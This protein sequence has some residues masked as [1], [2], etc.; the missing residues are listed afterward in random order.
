MHAVAAP[1]TVGGDCQY[2]NVTG[3]GEANVNGLYTL[4]G[5][6]GASANGRSTWKGL[7]A[8][9]LMYEDLGDD[10]DMAYV[11][12]INEKNAYTARGKSL[13]SPPITGW[14]RTSRK[15]SELVPVSAHPTPRAGSCSGL[16]A[17]S[18]PYPLPLFAR[19]QTFA[20]VALPPACLRAR[21]TG[22]GFSFPSGSLLTRQPATPRSGTRTPDG[23]T[24]FYNYKIALDAHREASIEWSDAA[25]S[26][27][28]FGSSSAM[29]G[30][31]RA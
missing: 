18:A 7:H 9:W 14:V 5:K 21:I 25:S 8:S 29:W 24:R 26:G 30:S 3:S 2:V 17:L 15:I 22:S 11:L 12:K 28:M 20:C 19:S 10:Q 4:Y 27:R 1:T 31:H 16:A 13:L 23:A 6:K